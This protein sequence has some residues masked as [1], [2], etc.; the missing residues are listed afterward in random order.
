MLERE[1]CRV[2]GDVGLH[3][4]PKP[5]SLEIDTPE[6]LALVEAIGRETEFQ[7]SVADV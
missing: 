5:L 7:S 6:D 2:G 1:S 3:V 4:M